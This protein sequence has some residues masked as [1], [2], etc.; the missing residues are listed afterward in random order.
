MHGLRAVMSV[1]LERVPG[2]IGKSNAR[3]CQLAR[4]IEVGHEVGDGWFTHCLQFLKRH[5]LR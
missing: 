1:T 4:V 3:R 5:L 2:R